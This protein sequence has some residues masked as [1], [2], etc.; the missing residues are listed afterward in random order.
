M[1]RII[2]VDDSSIIREGLRM[3]LS[4]R[5]EIEV[6]GQASCGNEAVALCRSLSPD[7]VLMDIKMANGCG[8][9]ATKKIKE[10]N[11][12]IKVLILTT[13]N[14]YKYITESI[15]NGADGYILKDASEENLIAAI[16]GVYSG[17]N[18]AQNAVF[19]KMKKNW[20]VEKLDAQKNQYRDFVNCLT[21]REK[22]I[23]KLLANSHTNKE[24]ADK[25]GIT[26]GTV[27]NIISNIIIKHNLKDKIQLLNYSI[28]GNL[29]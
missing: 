28:K 4:S 15:Q 12:A 10:A 14:L 20:A 1:I 21:E 23:V 19:E 29:V 13:F 3:L 9:E 5:D 24:I 2:I 18:V 16:K 8:I 27:K 6:I 7:L 11:P 25:L 26:E 17:L 22:E